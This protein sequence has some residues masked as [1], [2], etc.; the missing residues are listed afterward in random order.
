[1]APKRSIIL[2][3]DNIGGLPSGVENIYVIHV[4]STVSG[5]ELKQQAIEKYQLQRLAASDPG[6]IVLYASPLGAYRMRVDT[7]PVLP[8]EITDI[9]VRITVTSPPLACVPP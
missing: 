6:R 5:A 4:D 3:N 2:H 7:L 9:Y 8:I 1:M